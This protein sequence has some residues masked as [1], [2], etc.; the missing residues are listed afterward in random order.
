VGLTA[1]VGRG[2]KADT[3]L[4]GMHGMPCAGNVAGAL[5]RFS[6]SRQVVPPSD[7]RIGMAAFRQMRRRPLRASTISYGHGYDGGSLTR[8]NSRMCR[9]EPPAAVVFSSTPA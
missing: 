5:S 8:A 6:R 2:S 7:P 9:A 4:R 1:D 3:T